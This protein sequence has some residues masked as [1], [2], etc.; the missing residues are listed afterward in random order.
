MGDRLGVGDGNTQILKMSVS[1]RKDEQE[2]F[3]RSWA[4][5]K[6]EKEKKD[7][8]VL[9]DEA[10]TVRGGND[11][12]TRAVEEWE[13]WDMCPPTPGVRV[14]EEEGGWQVVLGV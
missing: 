9:Q 7:E 5:G 2:M 1:G 3:K 10:E 4:E 13:G 12:G 8:F 6:V 11:A 14:R